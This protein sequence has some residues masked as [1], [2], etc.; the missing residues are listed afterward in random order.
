MPE[1]MLTPERIDKIADMLRESGSHEVDVMCSPCIECK[2]VSHVIM[3]TEAYVAYLR[4]SAL[5]DCWPEGLPSQYE[6]IMTGTHDSCWDEIFDEE[7]K[8]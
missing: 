1:Y 5:K 3:P 7:Q 6:L 2:K 8:D 4:G